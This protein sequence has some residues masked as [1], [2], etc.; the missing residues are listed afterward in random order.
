MTARQVVRAFNILVPTKQVER[1]YSILPGEAPA[2]D[3]DEELAE[4]DG[5]DE[6]E[7]L[8]SST[9]GKNCSSVGHLLK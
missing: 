2:N 8:D 7:Q 9:C 3:D 1:T 6:G 5:I 4:P